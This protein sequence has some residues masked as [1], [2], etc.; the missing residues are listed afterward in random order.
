MMQL[1]KVCNHPKALT[2]TIDR[3]RAAAACAIPVPAAMPGMCGRMSSAHILSGRGLNE[4]DTSL[5]RVLAQDPF[6]QLRARMI[7]SAVEHETAPSKMM[8]ALAALPWGFV[9]A[10]LA[11]VVW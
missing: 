9:L 6:I 10:A 3:E 7:A 5:V 2:L 11:A 4:D 1:Q 8:V